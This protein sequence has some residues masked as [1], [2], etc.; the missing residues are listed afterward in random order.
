MGSTAVLVLSIFFRIAKDFYFPSF[1][2]SMKMIPPP[3]KENTKLQK[4]IILLF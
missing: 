4:T 3:P 2:N 1:K